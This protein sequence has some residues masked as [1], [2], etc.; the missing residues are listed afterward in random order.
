L[1]FLLFYRLAGNVLQ[2]PYRVTP[3][4]HAAEQSAAAIQDFIGHPY[5]DRMLSQDAPAGIA[6][7]GIGM[8]FIFFH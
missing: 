2:G 1:S 6:E 4:R 8:V 7:W 5:R 3:G